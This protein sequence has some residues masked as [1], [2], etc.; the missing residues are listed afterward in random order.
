MRA[1]ERYLGQKLFL[2][3]DWKHVLTSEGT[4][5]LDQL[6]DLET[7]LTKIASPRPSTAQLLAKISAGT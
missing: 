3:H 5:L 2:R 4:R 7:H 1:L 6:A